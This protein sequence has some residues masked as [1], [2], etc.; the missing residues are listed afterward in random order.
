LNYLLYESEVDFD[1]NC[2]DNSGATAIIWASF[3]G[4]EI[5]LTYLLAQP[6]IAI[7]VQNDQGETPLHLAILSP[8]NNSPTNLV[9][10]LL[11]KGADVEMKD[12]KGRTVIDLCKKR[13][14]KVKML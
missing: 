8:N 12:K 4:A 13:V 1:I 7:N 5:S 14:T 3:C 11:I 9:K 2:V 10:R 6:G